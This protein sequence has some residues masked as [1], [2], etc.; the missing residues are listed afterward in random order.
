MLRV[1][2]A[3]RHRL[4]EIIGNLAE[5]ITEARHNGWHGEVEGLQTSLEAAKNK[6][7]TIDRQPATNPRALTD[8]GI[9]NIGRP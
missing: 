5:R 3:Q 9:P 8:L 1:D 6:L 7:A 2:P 4:T